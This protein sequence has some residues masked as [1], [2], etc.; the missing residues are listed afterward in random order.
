MLATW[1][2]AAPLAGPAWGPELLAENE[3]VEGFYPL[4]NGA[5]F[6]GWHIRGQ[7]KNAFSA[8]DGLLTTTGEGG[9][10]WLFTTCEYENFVLRY[11]YRVFKQDDNSGVAV[12]ATAQ[13]NPAFSGMEIQVLHP[14]QTPRLG[15][16]GALYGAAAPAMTA[17]KPYGEWNEVEVLCDGP[18]IRTMMNGQTLYDINIDTFES[19][20]KEHPQLKDR[21]RKGHIAIQ[22]YGKY[23]EFRRI[24][25]KPLPGGEGWRSLSP[26]PS[27]EGW[28]ELGN[29]KWHVKGDG[30]LRAEGAP[31][32]S[33]LRTSGEFGDFELRLSARTHDKA[34]S[35]VFFR[36]HG[37]RLWPRSYEAQISHFDSDYFTGAIQGQVPACE[38]RALDDHWF[39]LH[40][41]AKGP[42]IQIVVNGETVAD[43]MSPK[44]KN[45]PEGWI[46]LQAPQP[47][48]VVEFKDIEV[49]SLE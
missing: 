46:C 25:V 33:A 5:D 20:D 43:Y 31:G 22:D 2:A 42:N 18:Q 34:D 39:Q 36:C 3:A 48:T 7:N 11:E 14:E 40:V 15:S 44:H 23:V 10:D 29:A 35:G 49:K 38:L 28:R 24:R 32:R 1:S 8:K 9:G 45:W 26:G 41:V 17:D 27:L 16:A 37:S 4:F 12:R 30:I 13:G 47:G 6:E 19:P 21:A